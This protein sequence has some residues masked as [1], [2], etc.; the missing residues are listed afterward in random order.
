[1]GGIGLRPGPP[2]SVN[3]MKRFLILFF[4]LCL[5]SQACSFLPGLSPGAE[6]TSPLPPAG[7]SG[8]L[9]T[10][11]P[12]QS[13]PRLDL[14]QSAFLPFVSSSEAPLVSLT[15]DS[16]VKAAL[17]NMTLSQKIGQ[18]LLANVEGNEISD[19]TCHFI[20]SL[21]PGGVF[22]KPGNIISP[23][24]MRRFTSELQKCAEDSRIPMFTALDHEGQGGNHFLEGATDFP[25]AL[26]QGAIG[27]P[28]YT[29]RASLAAGQELA[30]SG[31]NMVLGP[32]A[33]VLT[34]YYNG[35]VSKR[36]FGGD[37]EQVSLFVKQ[38]VEGYQRAG[39]ITVLKHFPGH[40]G[41]A[42]DSHQML[43]V[44]P[45]DPQRLESIYLP[46]FRSGINAGSQVVMF[47]HVAFPQVTGTDEPSSIS[48]TMVQ[49]LREDLGFQ[50]IIMTDAINMQ[51]LGETFDTSQASLKAVKAG[52]DM[53]LLTTPGQAR[54]AHEYL[55]EAVDSG[56]LS[57]DRVDEAVARIL[58][59]KIRQNLMSFP[60]S[61]GPEPDWK[62][63]KQLALDGERRSVA[64]YKNESGLIPL[65]NNIRNILVI[66]PDPSWEF[67]QQLAK[68]F[69][70]KGRKTK[71]VYYSSPWDGPVQEVEYL[72]TLPEQAR[73]YDL[74]LVFTWQSHIYSK[75]HED[76]WQIKLVQNLIKSQVPLIVVALKSPTDILDFPQV[77]VYISTIGTGPAQRQALIDTFFGDWTPVGKKPLPGLL[78]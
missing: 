7:D 6:P 12:P 5:V 64:L 24:Q 52:V 72:D 58:S 18:L 45:S 38:A 21:E 47:S 56:K 10:G 42:G 30:Y 3:S 14:P 25:S 63:D 11:I 31:V 54:A 15:A 62:A 22:F 50:G 37:P 35:V 67:Y 26:A 17:E 40:G 76:D 60:V 39:L 19:D 48:R 66:A 1:L 4:I 69:S 51:A 77:P 44:D 70:A 73:D 53:L 59:I 2:D 41:V 68:A 74:T 33:G 75:D 32:V 20:Q 23:Q 36:T 78:P 61:A 34:N 65:S 29:Y 8:S 9:A 16:R 27:D 46:S 43:P 55:M 71:F 49:L 28:D 57:M 13:D